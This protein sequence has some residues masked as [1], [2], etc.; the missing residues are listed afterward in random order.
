MKLGWNNKF[1]LELDLSLLT[2]VTPI[3]YCALQDPNGNIQKEIA[4]DHP[5]ELIRRDPY[6]RTYSDSKCLQLDHKPLI[7]CRY[8]PLWKLGLTD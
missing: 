8:V 3:Q 1:R 4:K 7:V 5:R 6:M 2:L